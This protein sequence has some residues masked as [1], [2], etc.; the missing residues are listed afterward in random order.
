MYLDQQ[1]V[2]VICTSNCTFGKMN[3]G[4][5]ADGTP[6]D[7]AVVVGPDAVAADSTT[8]AILRLNQGF[9]RPDSTTGYKDVNFLPNDYGNN[10]NC[11]VALGDGMLNI[12]SGSISSNLPSQIAGPIFYGGPSVGTPLQLNANE[13]GLAVSSDTAGAPGVK[14]LKLRVECS[15]TSGDVK[16]VALAGIAGGET[17]EVLITDGIGN[18]TVSQCIH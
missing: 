14:G 17:N 2:T 8:Q 11:T 10:C 7:A 1:N 6:Q 13:M 9:I 16:L 15:G 18:G 5:H 3:D 12:K 4:N